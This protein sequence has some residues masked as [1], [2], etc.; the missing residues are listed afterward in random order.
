MKLCGA[1]ALSSEDEF[2]DVPQGPQVCILPA[3][4]AGYHRDAHGSGWIE[5]NMRMGPL[6]YVAWRAYIGFARMLRGRLPWRAR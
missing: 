4:H 5:T 2:R 3:G 1:T 6:S